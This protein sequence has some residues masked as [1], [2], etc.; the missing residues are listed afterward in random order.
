MQAR[1]STNLKTQTEKVCSLP[2]VCKVSWVLNGR[3][4]IQNQCHLMRKTILLT[5]IHSFN[6]L[7]LMTSHIPG[8]R[9]QNCQDFC[10]RGNY[11]LIGKTNYQRT[12]LQS[13]C[14]HPHSKS[15]G[16]LDP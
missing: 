6:K 3:A 15:V 10:P 5:S 11:K 9:G 13:G 4:E 8:S 2:T 16:T 14:Y 7:S 1:A 12:P